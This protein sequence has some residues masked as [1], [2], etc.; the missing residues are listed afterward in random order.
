MSIERLLEGER[1]RLRRERTAAT[2]VV[3]A[4][5]WCLFVV[6]FAVWKVMVL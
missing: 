6:I 2:L 1:R 5:T 3:I 4:L